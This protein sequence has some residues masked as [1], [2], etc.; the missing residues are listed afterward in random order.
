MRLATLM[1]MAGF[2][3][4]LGKGGYAMLRAKIMLTHRHDFTLSNRQIAIATRDC[5]KI[6]Y[7]HK[8]AMLA[9][10]ATGALKCGAVFAPTF[11]K[12]EWQHKLPQ[13]TPRI[14]HAVTMNQMAQWKGWQPIGF[15]NPAK[16]S[17]WRTS[18]I[19][20]LR[21]RI[22]N[23]GV[24]ATI[25]LRGGKDQI[26]ASIPANTTAW[27]TFDTSK[28]DRNTT[29]DIMTSTNQLELGGIRL[30]EDSNLYW[31]W[32]QGVALT[33]HRAIPYQYTGDINW[34]FDTR[35]IF[36]PKMEFEVIDDH[37]ATILAKRN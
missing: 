4:H 15:T 12:E 5:D 7:M 19:T 14:S 13:L 35:E 8:D 30:D 23:L 11:E 33:Y 22:K 26:T 21:M 28:I 1:L 17:F 37:S 32:D 18:P 16:F 29:Y 9:Y 24:P 20:T 31:P 34:R 3:Y 10:F 6:L 2:S 36:P 25:T 27:I